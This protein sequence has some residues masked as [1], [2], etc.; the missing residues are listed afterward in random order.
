MQIRKAGKKFLLIRSFYDKEKK[1]C[2]GKTIGKI[3][4]W[5]TTI[6]KNLNLT[7]ILTDKEQKQLEEYLTK[8]Q[9]VRKKNNAINIL[10]HATEQINIIAD[11]INVSEAVESI[12]DE[13]K[14]E[15]LTAI[16]QLKKQLKKLK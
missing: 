13:E 6:P 5:E 1:R 2:I 16:N 7:D 12:S 10:S 3:G 11:A 4:V 15:I 9:N 14:K 8:T